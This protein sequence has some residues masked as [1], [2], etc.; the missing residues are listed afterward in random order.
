MADKAK[1]IPG[2]DIKLM[3]A[4]KTIPPEYKKI[5]ARQVFK[6][7]WSIARPYKQSLI[8]MVFFMVI[9]AGIVGGSIWMVKTAIDRFFESKDSSSVFFLIG[10][11]SLATVGRS[12]MEFFF[13]WNRTLV[14]GKIRDVLVVKAFRNLVFNPFHIHIQERDRKKYGWVLTDAMN[15]IN[16]I[17][18][19]FNSWVKHPFMVVSTLVALFAIAPLFTLIGILLTPLCVPCLLFLKR[20]IKEFI[21]QREHLIGRVEEVVSD[22]IRGIRIVKVFGLEENEINKL[23]RTVDMQRDLN[24]KNAF[25]TGLLSPVSELLGLIGLSGIIILGSRYIQTAAF[26]AGTFFVFIMSFVNIYRPMK[27]ISNGMLNYQMALDAGRRLII[28]RKNAAKEQVIEGKHKIKRFQSLDIEN[29]WFSYS[30]NPKSE[31]DYVL[32]GLNL[33]IK[34]GESIALTGAT[35]AGKSTFCDLIFRLYRQNKGNILINTIPVEQV[36][37]QSFREKFAL[38][39]QETIVF[40][41][42]L[43]ED[44]RVARPNASRR[45]VRE[46]AEAVGMSSF[47]N[48]LNRGLDTWI[49][50]RGIHCSGGQRQMI[51]LAR[52]LLKKPEFLVLDEA[53]SGIDLSTSRT[54]WKNIRKMLPECTILLISHHLPIIQYCKRVV[55]LKEGKLVQDAP[56]D[57]IMKAG[58]I[59]PELQPSAR[60]IP[61]GKR[62]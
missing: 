37:N 30:K 29:L 19:M 31:A 8:F 21:A 2:G 24:I 34:K 38:C 1:N 60:H 16:S 44:I 47:L 43:L 49:G 54:I 32:R 5:A 27:Q 23:E 25:Y 18:G 62:S 9:Q 40:N 3:K 17:F 22:S 10:A 33:S 57:E 28:L 20:K 4:Y 46:V 15:F 11:L 7:F 39:S 51:A 13:N 50:N 48:S 55:M 59:P 56:A 45:Q 41:N 53:I 14:I 52:A 36:E 35:G 61:L 12:C 42:T 58:P 6:E 26:T